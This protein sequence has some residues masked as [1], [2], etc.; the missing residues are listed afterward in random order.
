[1]KLF[2]SVII[3]TRNRAQ[4]LA[5]CLDSI[6]SQTL[7][8]TQFEVLVIDNASTDDTKRIC[9]EYLSRLPNLR[10]FYEPVPGQH[11][12]RNAGLQHAKGEILVYGDDDIRA[13]PSWLEGITEAFEDVSTVLVGGK[14]IPDYES[15]PPAWV[16]QL[17]RKNKCG[18]TL[19]QYSL[20]DLG[21]EPCEISPLYI[22]GCNFSIRRK[23]LQ[24][25]GGFHPDVM[26][27][28]N[29]LYMGDG[30]TGVSRE[31]MIRGYR[32]MYWPKASVYHWVASSRMTLEYIEYR[33]Y[34]QGISDSYSR[35]RKSGALS[36]KD[37]GLIIVRLA[38]SLCKYL[39]KP[40]TRRLWRA[41]WRG[42][43]L[44]RSRAKHNLKLLGWIL[45]DNYLENGSI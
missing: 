21:D 15:S 6:N 8:K 37:E 44:H 35:I 3:P 18:R 22:Y 13:F 2:L 1:M 32:A 16:D 28:E 40:L 45:R 23:V 34:G 17:W 19:G 29:I 43:F 33:M 5:K 39:T 30:D 4:L 41:Y 12:G 38:W 9:E 42:Y 36:M 31:I 10:Y 27:R 11:A 26:P 20:V 24:A 14:N 25:I 7:E